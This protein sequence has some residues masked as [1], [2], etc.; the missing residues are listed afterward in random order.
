MST[1]GTCLGPVD[2]VNEL[3]WRAP[4]AAKVSRDHCREY[5]PTTVRAGPTAVCLSIPIAWVVVAAMP[6]VIGE[7]W[8]DTRSGND[9]LLTRRTRLGS[10]GAVL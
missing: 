6:I 3:G 8:L 9:Y 7:G 4:A 1:A 2:A 10:I 5:D